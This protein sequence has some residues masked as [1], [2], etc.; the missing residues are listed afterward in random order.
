MYQKDRGKPKALA[1]GNPVCQRHLFG[2]PSR[3]PP[4]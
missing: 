3:L 4:R 2:A 1:W